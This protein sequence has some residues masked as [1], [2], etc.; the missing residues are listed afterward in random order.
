MKPGDCLRFYS[1]ACKL[2]CVNW[3]NFIIKINLI[4]RALYILAFPSGAQER[5]PLLYCMLKLPLKIKTECWMTLPSD[6]VGQKSS[7]G[8]RTSPPRLVFTD[9]D[10]AVPHNSL[11][12][13]W[14]YPDIWSWS[15][16]GQRWTLRLLPWQHQR[17]LVRASWSI[18]GVRQRFRK[19][20][21]WSVG[22][23]R[24]NSGSPCRA[25]VGFWELG[26]D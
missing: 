18:E 26:L 9:P 12:F 7:P 6:P 13:S 17:R 1:I 25:V 24:L 21:R 15:S 5:G 14:R 20:S 11:P 8:W 4:I 23:Q 16:W 2:K 19:L 10:T 3:Y 22:G